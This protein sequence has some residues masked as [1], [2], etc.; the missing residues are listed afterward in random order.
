MAESIPY[1]LL[2]AAPKPD[3]P[4]HHATRYVILMI[5]TVDGGYLICVAP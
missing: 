2:A 1:E 5:A 4:Q 3:W